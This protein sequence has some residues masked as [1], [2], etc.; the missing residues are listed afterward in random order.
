MI[1]T[2]VLDELAAAELTRFK[3]P[4][5]TGD[6]EWTPAMIRKAVVNVALKVN[7]PILSLNQ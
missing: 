2:F 4:W 1:V 3:S 6:C 7:K 5:L